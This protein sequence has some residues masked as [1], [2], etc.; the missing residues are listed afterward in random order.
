M[1]EI[2]TLN[3]LYKIVFVEKYS[4]AL[5]S[6]TNLARI[7]DINTLTCMLHLVLCII[8][9]PVSDLIS[10]APYLYLWNHLSITYQLVNK[11]SKI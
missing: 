2:M 11:K 6:L 9:T 4:L 3:D 1:N 7:P 5:C 8:K 10:D